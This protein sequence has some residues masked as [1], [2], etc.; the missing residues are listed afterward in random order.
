MELKDNIVLFDCFHF[1]GGA[2]V[3]ELINIL[4]LSINL[5]RKLISFLNLN[6]DFLMAVLS[7]WIFFAKEDHLFLLFSKR[8][9]SFVLSGLSVIFGYVNHLV[10]LEFVNLVA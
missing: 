10:F 7:Q 1:D 6:V 4:K 8:E 3:D 9:P 2:G 5:N